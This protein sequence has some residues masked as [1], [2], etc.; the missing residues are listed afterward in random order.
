MVTFTVLGEPVAKGRPRLGKFGT[1]T[2]AKTVE[3]ENLVKLSYMEQ[4]GNKKLNNE[5]SVSIHAYFKIPKSVSKNQRE[6]MLHN[7]IRPTKRPD[8]DNICKAILDSLNNIAYNDDSQVV[9]L[10]MYKLYS[11]FPRV[12]I[13]LEEIS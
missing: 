2:P 13:E 1:Y 11:D 10:K 12:E 6:L 8:L 5:L 7:A 9:T 3:Y 4:V